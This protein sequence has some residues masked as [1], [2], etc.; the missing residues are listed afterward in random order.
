MVFI[1]KNLW[2]SIS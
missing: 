2:T 1:A